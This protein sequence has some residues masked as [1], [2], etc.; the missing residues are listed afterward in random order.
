[1]T[2]TGTLERVD[3]GGGGWALKADDG[4]RYELHGDVPAG[5]A[6]KRVQVEGRKASRMGFLMTG[7]PGIEVR[8]VKG[9]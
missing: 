4:Q 9:E 2:F 8:S 1:M 7:D 3:L 6:G 5:L